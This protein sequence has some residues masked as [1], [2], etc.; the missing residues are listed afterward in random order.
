MG[1]MGG[2]GWGRTCSAE[3]IIILESE[4]ERVKRKQE[5]EAQDR[6]DEEETK[7]HTI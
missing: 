2:D 1:G 7:R 4:E 6:K 5:K 3:S